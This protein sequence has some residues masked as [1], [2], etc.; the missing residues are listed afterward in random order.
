[1]PPK[2]ATTTKTKRPASGRTGRPPSDIER[3]QCT[4]Y[5]ETELREKLR[6]YAF[7]ERM[8][9]SAVVEEA[10]KAFLRGKRL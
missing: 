1:M 7:K 2:A 4:V 3:V 6:K 10:L 9:Q 5:L 8:N